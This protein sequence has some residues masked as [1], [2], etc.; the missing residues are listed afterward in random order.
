MDA[1]LLRPGRFDLKIF[2]PPPNEEDRS[3]IIKTLI[4]SKELPCEI[5][6]EDLKSI[7]KN[8]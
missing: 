5:N 7:A 2:I 3:G 1:A 4:R 6:D 8:T